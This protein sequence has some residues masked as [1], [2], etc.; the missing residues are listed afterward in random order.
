[1]MN[2]NFIIKIFKYY[3]LFIIIII[4]IFFFFTL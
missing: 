4:N 2:D 3:K 1:M